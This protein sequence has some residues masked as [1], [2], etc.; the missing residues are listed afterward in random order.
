M[1]E[2]NLFPKFAQALIKNGYLSDKNI[3]LIDVGARGGIP[4]YFSPIETIIKSVGFEADKSEC[5]RLN[6]VFKNR[7]FING[8]VWKKKSNKKFYK[9]KFSASC[10]LYPPDE[11]FWKRTDGMKNLE[12]IGEIDVETDSLSNLIANSKIRDFDFMKLDLEGAELDV[13]V[14]SPATIDKVIAVETEVRFFHCNKGCSVFSEMDEFLRKKEFF[15]FDL[16]IH[17]YQRNTL[18]YISYARNEHGEVIPSST[19]R[20]QVGTGN[21]LYMRDFLNN[22][23]PKDIVTPEKIL[24]AIIIFELFL[25]NDCAIELLEKYYNQL[26]NFPFSFERS[27]NLLTPQFQSKDVSYQEYLDAVNSGKDPD[28]ES[29]FAEIIS[30]LRR[31][32]NK[33]LPDRL[34]KLITK[35]FHLVK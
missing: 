9:T 24:K 11:Q 4:P 2:F 25:L 13:M 35:A 18:P 32:K 8:F 7:E 22:N 19:L 3:N 5:K 1:A 31:I 6:A 28:I 16:E 17:K 15:L 34:S 10:G 27:R 14:G 12:V 26:P 21:A 30:L 20:G 23:I 29:I 33:H